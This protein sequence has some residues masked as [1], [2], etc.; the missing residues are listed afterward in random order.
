MKMKMKMRIKYLASKQKETYS[1]NENDCGVFGLG[2]I[3]QGLNL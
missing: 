1:K 3:E 2:L